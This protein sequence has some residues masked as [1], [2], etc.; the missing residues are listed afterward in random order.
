MAFGLPNSCISGD[1]NPQSHGK[2]TF[3]GLKVST[4]QKHQPKGPKGLRGS[5]FSESSDHTASSAAHKTP[6][7]PC[8][9]RFFHRQVRLAQCAPCRPAKLRS[10]NHP[11]GHRTAVVCGFNSEGQQGRQK[12]CQTGLIS[13]AGIDG[14]AYLQRC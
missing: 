2:A 3:N 10:R 4:Y 5:Y 7:N 11:D 13:N 14:I 8:H 1:P 6:L 9:R 12:E